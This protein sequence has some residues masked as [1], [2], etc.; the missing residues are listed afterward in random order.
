MNGVTVHYRRDAKVLEIDTKVARYR[1]STV[2]D[3]GAFGRRKF[4]NV[5]FAEY[6]DE[7]IALK[8]IYH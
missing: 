4:E 1:D 5:V 3:L 7:R 6:A 8:F 2:H